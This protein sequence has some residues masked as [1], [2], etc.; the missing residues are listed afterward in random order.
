MK[1]VDTNILVRYYTQDDARQPRIAT[2]VMAEEPE[3]FVPDTVLIELYFVLRYA[4]KYL[5]DREKVG[6]VIRH[7]VNLPNVTVHDYEQ[8]TA[9]LDRQRHGIEFPDAFHLATSARCSEF[10]TFDDRRLARRVR[11]TGIKPR[12]TVPTA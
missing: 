10:L 4:E 11:R 9:A 12:V 2:R 8:V 6:G 1:A 7:L 3:L 5:F